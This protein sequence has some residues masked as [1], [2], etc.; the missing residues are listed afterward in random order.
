MRA[1][2]EVMRECSA[3]GEIDDLGSPENQTERYRE[4]REASSTALVQKQ[5][6]TIVKDELDQIY[7]KNGGEGLNACTNEDLTATSS[8]FPATASSSGPGSSRI[9][10]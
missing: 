1:E 4:L 10:S 8:G 9:A 2:I 7:T 5:R 6:E 3:R